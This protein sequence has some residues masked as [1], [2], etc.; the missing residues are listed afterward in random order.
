[1]KCFLGELKSSLFYIIS[2][3]ILNIQT[4]L[5]INK[6]EMRLC[7]TIARCFQYRIHKKTRS[8]EATCMIYSTVTDLAKFLGLS[9][10]H[11]FCKAA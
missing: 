10:S 5:S 9:T 2:I 1:M 3:D 8:I 11:S 6:H 4:E 7:T